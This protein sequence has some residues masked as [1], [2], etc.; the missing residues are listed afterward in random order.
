MIGS[1]VIRIKSVN[2][3][4]EVP[5]RGFRGGFGSINKYSN[6]LVATRYP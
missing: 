3:C 2:K 5:L 6:E 4:I 1:L